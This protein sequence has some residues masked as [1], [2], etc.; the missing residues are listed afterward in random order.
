M[1]EQEQEEAEYLRKRAEYWRIWC[2]HMGYSI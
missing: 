1:T 2:W